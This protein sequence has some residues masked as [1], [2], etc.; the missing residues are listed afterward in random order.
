MEVLRKRAYEG[1]QRQEWS[2]KHG[3]HTYYGGPEEHVE[4]KTNPAQQMQRKVMLQ[5][6]K[7]V[8]LKENVALIVIYLIL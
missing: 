5:I 2:K 1:K 4:K 7:S 3:H 6:S 8:R